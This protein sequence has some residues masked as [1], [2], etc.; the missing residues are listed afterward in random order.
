MGLYHK[1]HK[2]YFQEIC[3]GKYGYTLLCSEADQKNYENKIFDSIYGS[4]YDIFK[5]PMLE[6]DNV[7]EISV[8]R[9]E[10]NSNFVED[11]LNLAVKG[12]EFELKQHLQDMNKK[13]HVVISADHGRDMKVEPT[14]KYMIQIFRKGFK[15]NFLYFHGF[16]LVERYNK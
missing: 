5:I 12:E 16:S 13:L 10:R 7:R 8:C 14:M 1:T 9:S 15:M 4:N 6:S 2:T 11:I 3:K